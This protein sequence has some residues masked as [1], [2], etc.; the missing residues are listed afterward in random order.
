MYHQAEKS[1]DFSLIQFKTLFCKYFPEINKVAD[2]ERLD[3]TLECLFMLMDEDRD[4][5]VDIDEFERGLKNLFPLARMETLD[6]DGEE[7]FGTPVRRA[8]NKVSPQILF[9]KIDLEATGKA[10]LSDMEAFAM[11]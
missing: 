5:W 10:Y 11:P 2:F 4:G 9:A 1:S 8:G 7:V 6:A 3:Q